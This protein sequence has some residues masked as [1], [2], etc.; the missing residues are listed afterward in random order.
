MSTKKEVLD[1]MDEDLRNIKTELDATKEWTRTAMRIADALEHLAGSQ[2][3]AQLGMMGFKVTHP[4][5]PKHLALCP[6]CNMIKG[7]EP[8]SNLAVGPTDGVLLK[9]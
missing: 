4:P 9:R 2:V 8:P 5:K 3:L 1:E 7:A 6:A